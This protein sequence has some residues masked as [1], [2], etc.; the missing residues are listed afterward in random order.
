MTESGPQAVEKRKPTDCAPSRDGGA[1]TRARDAFAPPVPSSPKGSKVLFYLALLTVLVAFCDPN[2]GVISI[3]LGFLLKNKLALDSSQI[4]KFRLV[5]AI[6]LFLSF[7]F[8]VIR[9]SWSPLGLMD[10]GYFMTFGV[11][12]TGLYVIFA[13][14]PASYP[15]LLGALFLLT[16]CYLFIDSA[17][18][19][20]NSNLARQHVMPGQVSA[21]W[22]VFA[23]LPA[24]AALLVGGRLSDSLEHQTAPQA[25]KTLFLLGAATFSALAL[26]GAWKPRTV[27]ED[28]TAQSRADDPLMRKLAAFA[29]HWPVYPALTIWILFKFA[30][31]SSTPLQYYLQDTLHAE[32]HF[33]GEWNAIFYASR[34]PAFVA[35][36]LL[37]R[38]APLRMFLWCGTLLTIPQFAPLLFVHSVAGA[39]LA[40]APIGAMGA[41]ANAAYLDLVIRSCPRGLEGTTLMLAGSLYYLA[42]RFGDV[43][44]IRLYERHGGFTACVVV[45]TIAYSLI[46]LVIPLAPKALVAYADGGFAG[47]RSA[48]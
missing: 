3:P 13:Y 15:V 12:G 16:A 17:N 21:L 6:P 22:S 4:A 20:L 24:I 8:G 26:Y 47:D 18:S 27:F 23:A 5:A 9:D 45:I 43:L 46:L 33:W 38:R 7:A 36:G 25:L 10:R 35:Y 44:G 30:P 28:L 31:G 37:C 11:I 41:V 2:E 42:D 39:L 1:S 19:G 34:I 40:A 14:S 32:D 29:G 48:P